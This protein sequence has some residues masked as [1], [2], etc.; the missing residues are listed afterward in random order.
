MLLGFYRSIKNHN[1]CHQNLKKTNM[2]H[3]QKLILTFCALAILGV[4]N[5]QYQS[6]VPFG[7]GFKIEGEDFSSKFHL[8]IQPR[9]DGE[10]YTTDSTST[11]QDR[12]YLRRARIKGSGWVFNEKW[13][14]KFEFDVVNGFVLDAVVKYK[15][16]PGW[17]FWFGQTKLPGNRE[18]VISSQNMEFV[19]RSL[20]NSKFTLDRDAGIQLRHKWSAG[21]FVIKEAFAWS[22][23]EGLNQKG[24]N[25]AWD[26]TARLDLYPMGEFTGKGDYI[27][28]DINREETPKLALSATYNLNMDAQRTRGQMGDYIVDDLGLIADSSVTDIVS[29]QADMMF[30]YQ[31]FSIMG[32]YAQRQVADD[33]GLGIY[34]T[35]SAMNLHIG[36]VLKNN[37]AFAGRYTMV[38]PDEEVGNDMTQY[39]FSVSKY[40]V[41]HNLKVQA[42]AHVLEVDGSDDQEMMFRLQMEVAF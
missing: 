21:N 27:G 28:A 2:K 13:N 20:L 9:W 23:G 5:G 42:D 11:F 39:G 22:Q 16:A 38:N 15:F 31:G 34:Y 29:I 1:I 35:G 32:E 12:A 25:D 26:I 6:D 10:L 40:L 8:R 37:W 17:E 41:G 4:V 3:F 7:K 14:Y 24:W 30:K 18:R 19:D 36:Y 33:K